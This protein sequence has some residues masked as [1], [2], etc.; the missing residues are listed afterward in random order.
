M[1]AVD[2][3]APQQL[4]GVKSDDVAVVP[5]PKSSMDNAAPQSFNSKLNDFTR[6]ND[7]QSLL[8]DINDIDVNNPINEIL[9]YLYTKRAVMTDKNV[10]QLQL[11]SDFAAIFG[12]SDGVLF[13]N[14]VKFKESMRMRLLKL[15]CLKPFLFNDPIPLSELAIKSSDLYKKILSAELGSD[16]GGLN[17]YDEKFLLLGNREAA[18]TNKITSFLQRVRNSQT[19]QNRNR[20]R[21]KLTTGSVVIETDYFEPAEA[22]DFNLFLERKRGEVPCFNISLF[23]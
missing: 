16:E 20:R 23:S 2:S 8:P 1:S 5:P 15:R 4:S 22:E 7:F 11:S 19:S 21:K 12:S 17:E 3:A 6:E 14:Y 10:F 13:T 18:N 9:L